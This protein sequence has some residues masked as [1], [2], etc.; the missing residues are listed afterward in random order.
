MQTVYSDFALLISV[1]H[2]KSINFFQNRLKIKLFLKKD[3]FQALGA[4]PLIPE[5][6][7]SPIANFWLR[8]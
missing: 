4:S 2:F 8:A 7:P 3:F 1:P 5:T 6:T